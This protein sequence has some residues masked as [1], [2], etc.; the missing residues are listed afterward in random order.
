M[1]NVVI[2]DAVRADGLPS[3]AAPSA[4][5]AEDLSAHLMR[6]VLSRNPALDAA[7]I[8]DILLWDCAADAGARLQHRPQRRTA[9]RNP[10]P[11]A[12]GDR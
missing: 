8:D 9:G 12:G 11:R 2:V 6:E 1:E 7:E 4:R 10:A 5:C 3:R